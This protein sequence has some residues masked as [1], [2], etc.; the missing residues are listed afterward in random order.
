MK[1]GTGDQLSPAC[2]YPENSSLGREREGGGGGGV[3]FMM[4]EREGR[5]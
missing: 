3:E 4:K 1:L 2:V 5:K